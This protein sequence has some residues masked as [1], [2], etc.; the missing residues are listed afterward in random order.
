MIHLVISLIAVLAFVGRKT[1]TRHA[2]TIQLWPKDR[3][4]AIYADLK[5]VPVP[6]PLDTRFDTDVSMK[7]SRKTETDEAVVEKARRVVAA[8]GRLRW[9]MLIYAVM[10]LGL[11]IYATLAG[12]RKVDQ[13]GAEQM[14]LGFV[15]GLA[16]AVVWTT[17]GLMGALCLGKFLVGFNGDLRAQALLVRYYD[18]LRDLGEL[19]K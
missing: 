5:A 7:M 10:P 8:S 3:L 11:T 18:R 2:A 16:L 1:Q 6:M 12:I 4:T 15:Y 19:P 17:F 14:S 9:V 13:L